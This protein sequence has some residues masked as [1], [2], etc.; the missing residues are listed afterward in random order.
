MK[1]STMPHTMSPMSAQKHSRF[2]YSAAE[3]VGRETMMIPDELRGRF[4]QIL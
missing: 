1:M 4:D 2:G 3:V